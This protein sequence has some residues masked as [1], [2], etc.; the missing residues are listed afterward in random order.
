[1]TRDIVFVYD[2]FYPDYSAGGPVTS[3]VNLATMLDGACSVKVLTSAYRYDSRE[4]F[5]G[6]PFNQWTSWGGFTVWYADSAKEAERAI[7]TLSPSATVYLNGIFSKNYFLRVLLRARRRH[8]DIV[9][10]PRG[11][12]QEG[13][14]KDKAFKKTVYLSFLKASGLLKGVSWHATDSQELTDIRRQFGAGIAGKIIPNVPR[15]PPEH[16]QKIAKQ[17]GVLKLV[18]FSLVT[19]KKNIGFAIDLIASGR[20]AG[21]SLDIAGPVKDH[22]YWTECQPAVVGSNGSVNYIGDINPN[23]VNDFLSQYHLMILPTHGENFGHAIVEALSSWR[24]VLISG[25]T[26]WK[27]VTFLGES[28]S[29]PLDGSLWE[30]KLT[31]ARNWSQDDFDEA[32]AAAR[33]YFMEKINLPDIRAMYLSLFGIQS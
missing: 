11:M 10:S 29:I 16:D 27:D 7:E 30:E 14:L 19:R 5:T 33:K 15:K 23:R 4:R 12:L 28:F 25:H 2:H 17:R 26:P 21:I 22:D 6:I 31:K 24:P 18:Y 8:L 13:A 20:L 3:L 9:I 1:M 32:C